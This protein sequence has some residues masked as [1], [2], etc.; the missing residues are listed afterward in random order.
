MAHILSVQH[1]LQHICAVVAAQT[2]LVAQVS[3]V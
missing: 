2:A 1:S 3:W